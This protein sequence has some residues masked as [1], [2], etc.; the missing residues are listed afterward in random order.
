MPQNNNEPASV[1]RDSRDFSKEILIK[2][3]SIIMKEFNKEQFDEYCNFYNRYFFSENSQWFPIIIYFEIKKDIAG[4]LYIFESSTSANTGERK[5]YSYLRCIEKDGKF[6]GFQEWDTDSDDY[7]TRVE[8]RQ[9]YNSIY[10][11][12]TSLLILEG[13]K[14]ELSSKNKWC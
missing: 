12:S 8:K 7:H 4:N 2:L 11:N 13:H 6:W 14:L 5:D 10:E 1:L 3:E 9:K